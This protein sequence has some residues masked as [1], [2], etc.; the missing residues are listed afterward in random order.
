MRDIVI[1]E[2]VQDIE[3]SKGGFVDMNKYIGEMYRPKDYPE[4]NGKEPDWVAS[5]CKLSQKMLIEL[6]DDRK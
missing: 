2:T 4:L 3:K 1:S 6:I 5:E